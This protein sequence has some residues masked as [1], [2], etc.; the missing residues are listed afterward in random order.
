MFKAC[1]GDPFQI[2]GVIC[3]TAFR[4][5]RIVIETVYLDVHVNGFTLSD[6]VAELVRFFQF[7]RLR[8][9]RMPRLV[10]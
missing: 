5:C 9:V 6:L 3:R 1:F 10:V 8:Y 4:V 2:E 7:E